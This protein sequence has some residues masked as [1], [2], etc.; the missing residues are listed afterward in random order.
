M[1]VWWP[2]I[3][4]LAI[5]EICIFNLSSFNSRAALVGQFT[6]LNLNQNLFKHF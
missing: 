5:T 3:Q 1:S 2:E 6:R 4:P